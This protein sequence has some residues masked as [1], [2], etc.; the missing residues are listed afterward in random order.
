MGLRFTEVEVVKEL[1]HA[2][3]V[4]LLDIRISYKQQSVCETEDSVKWRT[5]MTVWKRL[6]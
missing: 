6:E 1:L 4:T 5:M 3:P 2:F